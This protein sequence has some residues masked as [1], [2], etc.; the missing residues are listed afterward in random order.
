MIRRLRPDADDDGGYVHTQ[1][2]S[3]R[4]QRRLRAFWGCVFPFPTSQN[5]AGKICG[6]SDTMR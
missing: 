1:G 5:T 6:D 4:L 3:A 2:P